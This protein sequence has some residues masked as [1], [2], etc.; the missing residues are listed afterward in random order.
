MSY[1]NK[2]AK[3]H[4]IKL[5]KEKLHAGVLCGMYSK[6][7]THDIKQVN[8]KMCLKKHKDKN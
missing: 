2:S 6:Y 4:L 7:S 3:I 8:C 5:N 1:I